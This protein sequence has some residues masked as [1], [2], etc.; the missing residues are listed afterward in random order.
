MMSLQIISA[1]I[2]VLVGYYAA[3]VRILYQRF[4][5]T[6]GRISKE[7]LIPFSRNLTDGSDNLFREVSTELPLY[8]VIFQNNAD[9]V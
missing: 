2:Y 5:K 7:L 9:I 6:I 3:W 8:T 1:L 4:G